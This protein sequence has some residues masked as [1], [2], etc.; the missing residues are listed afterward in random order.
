MWTI[1]GPNAEVSYRCAEC[2]FA[3]D[4]DRDGPEPVESFVGRSGRPVYRVVTVA[5]EEVHRCVSPFLMLS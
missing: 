1:S 5:G 2:D 4:V 3:I